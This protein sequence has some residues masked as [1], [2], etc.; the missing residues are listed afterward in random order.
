MIRTEILSTAGDY[1]T[2]DRAA[3]H[4]RAEGGFAAIAQ[5][6]D[7]LDAARGDRPRSVLDVALYMAGLKLVRAATNPAHAD[8]WIDLAGYAACGGEIATG[9]AE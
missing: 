1:V 9:G 8:N 3:T 4:G 5:V 6:W 7:A 2:R